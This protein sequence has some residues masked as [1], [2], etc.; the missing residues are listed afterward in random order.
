MPYE[1]PF[2]ANSRT[3]PYEIQHHLRRDRIYDPDYGLSRDPYWYSKLEKDAIFGFL[4]RFRRQMVAGAEWSIEGRTEDHDDKALAKIMEILL[5]EIKNFDEARYLLSDSFLK[6]STWARI[7]GK[8]VKINLPS[9]GKIGKIGRPVE[10]YC[11]T[12]LRDVAKRRFELRRDLTTASQ[13]LKDQ[14]WDWVFSGHA[15]RDWETNLS[16]LSNRR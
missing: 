14:K 16:N 1:I 15:D 7:Y 5:G 10:F 8:K 3:Y 2:N 11:V 13:D 4:I 12:K 6:G 9:I